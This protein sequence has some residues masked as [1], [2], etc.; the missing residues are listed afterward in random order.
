MR[1]L[2]TPP[3]DSPIAPRM[4]EPPEFASILAEH[5]VHVTDDPKR[6]DLELVGGMQLWSG[7]NHC[8]L[9]LNRVVI[10]DGEPPQPEYLLPHYQD[11]RLRHVIT[12]LNGAYADCFA[13][14]IP[15]PDRRERTWGNNKICRR[16]CQ[17]ATYRSRGGNA[18]GG[19]HLVVSLNG[20]LY[21]NRVLCVER[22]KL[23][24]ELRKRIPTD[25]YGR[26]WPDGIVAG[27]SRN[28][29]DFLKERHRICSQYDFDLCWENMEIPNYVSEKF[30]APLYAGVVPIYWG[31]REWHARLPNVFVD[32]R[33]YDCGVAGYDTRSLAEDLGDAYG[34]MF[35]A[36]QDWYRSL[37]RDSAHVSW[38]KAAHW[39]GEELTRLAV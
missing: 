20:E 8:R 14:H 1:L 30:W 25:I 9:P 32:A 37:P 16:I 21:A 27:N 18:N 3:F 34:L 19:S 39:L 10:I 28:R 38:V 23:G 31:P 7:P 35:D 22:V 36:S 4:L 13:F 29:V 26:G 33:C 5:G 6:A 12:P 24:L 17:F 2:I 15:P 11:T